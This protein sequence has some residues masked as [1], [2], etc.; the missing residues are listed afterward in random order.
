M[1]FVV[2]QLKVLKCKV[3][4]AIGKKRD[5]EVS[6]I[7]T[8]RKERQRKKQDGREGGRTKRL[9]LG[10]VQNEL[11]HRCNGDETIKRPPA[12]RLF[13]LYLATLRLIL[14]VG[15]GFGSRVIYGDQN[16]QV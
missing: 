10:L 14:T 1:R 12:A 4:D 15:K 6:T 3:L 2:A 9:K 5:T 7:K 8:E 11:V 13:F 16:T